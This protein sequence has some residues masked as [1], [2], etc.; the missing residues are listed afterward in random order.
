M[1]PFDQIEPV[2]SGTLHHD[3]RRTLRSLL[4]LGGAG[5]LA[6]SGGAFAAEAP[7]SPSALAKDPL[8]NDRVQPWARPATGV[9]RPGKLP[10]VRVYAGPDRKTR[11]EI[12]EIELG[13]EPIPGLFIQK[14]ETFAIRVIAPGTK[15][16]WHVPSRRRMVTP[17][18]GTAIMTLRD[19]ST[20]TVKPGMV[21]LVENLDSDGHL[22]SFD[23]QEYTITM[24]VGLPRA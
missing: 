11:V 14:A 1:D 13:G 17:L 21:V 23:E 9:A 16:D 7:A 3:R 22:G 10:F 19:G 20:Y 2:I 12:Q 24:D 4:G 6:A 5:L 8:A 15:F 18:R